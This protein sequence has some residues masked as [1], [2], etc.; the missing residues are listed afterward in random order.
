[1]R[2]RARV[3]A[4]HAQIRSALRAA[5]WTVV[6]CA[7]VGSGF[8]D[9]LIA[10]QGRLVM[11]EIKDGAKVKSAQKLTADEQQF[12]ASMAAA[13]VIVSVITSV[14]EALALWVDLDL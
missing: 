4:N 11:V 14:E 13:G 7:G 12:H 10:K 3:D 2:R 8:P 9:L 6:D 1:M 5:G